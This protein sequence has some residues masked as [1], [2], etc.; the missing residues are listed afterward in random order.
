MNPYL[1]VAGNPRRGGKGRMKRN[2]AGV[3][4]FG[5]IRWGK[6][7]PLMAT[8]GAS[9][10]VTKMAPGFL[11]LAWQTN[12]WARYGTQVAVGIVGWWGIRN[13]GKSDDHATV[14]L[15]VAGGGI[16]AEWIS[17]YL[18]SYFMPMVAAPTGTAGLGYNPGT[19]GRSTEAYK[20]GAFPTQKRVGAYPSKM[21]RTF[22]GMGADSV[23]PYHG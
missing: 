12:V 14:W 10:V 23:S 8:A 5:G 22:A 16:V 17:N 9:A 4:D 13:W 6:V 18:L 19:Y 11:P 2:P 1:G 21:S 20:L 3:L 15:A 7:V